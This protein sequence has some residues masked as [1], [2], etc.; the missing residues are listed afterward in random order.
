MKFH[1]QSFPKLIMLGVFHSTFDLSSELIM[2]TAPET[3]SCVR[4]RDMKE[5]DT[6]SIGLPA[7]FRITD[8]TKLKG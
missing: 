6:T 7:N 5:F 2:S 3:Q 1:Q 8:Y 4:C